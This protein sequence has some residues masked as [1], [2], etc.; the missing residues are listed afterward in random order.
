MERLHLRPLL[1]HMH[2]SVA[3]PHNAAAS[4]GAGSHSQLRERICIAS[5][6]APVRVP[7]LTEPGQTLRHA[8]QLRHRVLLRLP[9]PPRISRGLH[10]AF[11]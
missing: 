3:G 8:P 6:A 4:C 7:Y 5:D 2:G 9:P 11:E 1:V 10:G